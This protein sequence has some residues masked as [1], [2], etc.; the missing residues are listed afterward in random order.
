MFVNDA[1]ALISHINEIAN[2]RFKG[3]LKVVLH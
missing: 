3:L 2:T 1:C